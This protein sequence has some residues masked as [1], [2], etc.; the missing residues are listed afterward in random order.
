MTA[1]QPCTITAYDG[2]GDEGTTLYVLA[3]PNGEPITA[4]AWPGTLEQHAAALGLVAVRARSVTG[5]ECG[6]GDPDRTKA[7]AR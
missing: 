6:A 4:A 1:P 3:A 7:G 2:A 5:L